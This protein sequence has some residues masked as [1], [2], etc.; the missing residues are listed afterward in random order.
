MLV[1][2]KICKT[3]I[4]RDQAF[5]VVTNNRNNYYC[6]PEEF[7]KWNEEKENRSKSI[8]LSFQI[9]G[10]TTNTVLMKELNEI[11]KI[12]GFTKLYKYLETS[13]YDLTKIMGKINNE[14]YG[15]I[16]YFTTVVRNE[17]GKFK[18]LKEESNEVYNQDIVEVVSYKAN[19]KKSFFDFIDEY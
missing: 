3:K 9:I 7:S 4:E 14:E 1:A 10:K 8:D 15:R 16:R 6:N 2:C 19:K 18:E 17:I 13:L 5:R 11:G 12:H